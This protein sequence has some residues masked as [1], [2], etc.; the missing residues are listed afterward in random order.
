MTYATD[1]SGVRV[2][3]TNMAEKKVPIFAVLKGSYLHREENPEKYTKRTLF[4]FNLAKTN[5]CM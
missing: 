1:A 5:I 2:A 4:P 3:Q